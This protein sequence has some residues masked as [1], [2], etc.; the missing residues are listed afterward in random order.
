MGLFI[1]ASI[2]TVLEL[3]DYVYEVSC[4]AL[5]SPWLWSLVGHGGI[6]P[7]SLPCSRA[8]PRGPLPANLLAQ[9]LPCP[10]QLLPC[11]M[12]LACLP[13]G[14]S[15]PDFT[16]QPRRVSLGFSALPFPGPLPSLG[17]S[18]NPYGPKR[19]LRRHPSHHTL[20]PPF[21]PR[22]WCCGVVLSAFPVRVQDVESRWIPCCKQD[23][24]CAF[25]VADVPSLA[26][27][28]FPSFEEHGAARVQ[29]GCLSQQ[30]LLL[31]PGYKAQAVSPGQVPKEPQKEQ[32]GPG[33]CSEHG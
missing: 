8:L 5:P 25:P 20:I 21:L 30:M 15:S 13:A 16:L 1:G 12:S 26:T 9:T 22:H 19:L 6:K 32:R 10:E 11:S 27:W 23:L 17:S 24:A 31:P 7:P 14:R 28:P 29:R 4:L 33:R 18:S 3:V 2:L